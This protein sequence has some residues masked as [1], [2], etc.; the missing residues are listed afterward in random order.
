M[1]CYEA[2]SNSAIRQ[3]EDPKAN[4]AGESGDVKRTVSA[5]IRLLCR[6]NGQS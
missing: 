5:I 2:F 1:I 6:D 4:H 3:V